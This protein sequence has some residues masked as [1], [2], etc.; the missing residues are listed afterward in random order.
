MSSKISF[1]KSVHSVSVSQAPISNPS[2]CRNFATISSGVYRF[3]GI[4]VLL[5]AKRYS[6]SR[7]TS[8]RAD[9]FA[10]EA[11]LNH[12]RNRICPIGKCKKVLSALFGFL[13]SRSIVS[14]LQL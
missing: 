4:L 2:I 9:H 5:D 6:S 1:D 8:K 7:T 11:R 13:M 12:T 14:L 10:E 3:F